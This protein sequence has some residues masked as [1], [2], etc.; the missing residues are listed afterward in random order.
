MR[1]VGGF[2]LYGLAVGVIEGVW[3]V[4][5]RALTLGSW[6]RYIIHGRALGWANGFFAGGGVNL[7]GFVRFSEP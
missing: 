6:G 3:G 5:E 4:F 1:L 2:L 7:A